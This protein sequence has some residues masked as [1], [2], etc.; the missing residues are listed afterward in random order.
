MV[1]VGVAEAVVTVGVGELVSV[2]V[3]GVPP[4]V[5]GPPPPVGEPEPPVGEPEPEPLEEELPASLQSLFQMA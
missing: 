5:I 2:V 1:V 4:P 3:T